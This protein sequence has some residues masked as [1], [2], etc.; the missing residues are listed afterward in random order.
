MELQ[1]CCQV[2]LKYI[3][4]SSTKISPAIALKATLQLCKMIPH[5]LEISGKNLLVW[6]SFNGT[7]L[8]KAL[9]LLLIQ[10]IL[11]M[12]KKKSLCVA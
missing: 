6:C 7:N 9:L 2:Y 1:N 10:N 3:Q 8:A 5:Q 12:Q 4:S 11:C